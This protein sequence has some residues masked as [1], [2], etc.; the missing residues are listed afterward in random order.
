MPDSIFHN[1]VTFTNTINLQISRS[2]VALIV[3]AFLAML[4]IGCSTGGSAQFYNT[5]SDRCNNEV[6]VG[7]WLLFKTKYMTEGAEWVTSNINIF[8]AYEPKGLSAKELLTL[9]GEN[10]WPWLEEKI[11]NVALTS[12]MA[13][14]FHLMSWDEGPALHSL[15]GLTVFYPEGAN[16]VNLDNPRNIHVLFLR[17]I[18]KKN[19]YDWSV[20][21]KQN[22]SGRFYFK[23]RWS[24]YSSKSEYREKKSKI[25]DE[26]FKIMNDLVNSHELRINTS[27]N[28]TLERK[29]RIDPKFLSLYRSLPKDYFTD[30][31]P[32]NCFDSR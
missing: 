1:S 25:P 8:I 31:L 6:R 2:N 16:F 3:A 19:K 29:D 18:I 17:E 13:L 21:I 12:E 23:Q 5:T 10:D 22:R 15:A 26:P 11:D 20:Y 14:Y 30:R 9:D 4:L 28:T 32:N 24:W 27:V 7:P